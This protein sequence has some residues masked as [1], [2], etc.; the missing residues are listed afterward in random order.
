MSA[1][2]EKK[3]GIRILVL[4]GAGAKG[5]SQLTTLGEVMER[6]Q[7]QEGRSKPPDPHEC[8]EFIVG[9]DTAALTAAL[10]GRLRMPINQAIGCFRRLGEGVFSDKWTTS[11]ANR[12]EKLKQTLKDIVRGST[13]DEDEMIM[14]AESDPNCK[15]MIFAMAR[16]NLNAG[17]PTIFCS[18]RAPV[19][20]MGNCLIREAVCA[21][22][23]HPDYFESID[24]GEPP[25][26][27][28]FVTGLL[29]CSN[30]TAHA[31]GEIKRLYPD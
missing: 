26:R 7:G 23:A 4:E 20:Y 21:S 5:L 27:G 11:K 25:M 16:D 13:G 10:I 19:N 28:S 9:T 29:F 30:P 12:T 15:I 18:Y 31:L 1:Q 6:L 24:V 8:F 2:G 3:G 22:M 17:L 14:G